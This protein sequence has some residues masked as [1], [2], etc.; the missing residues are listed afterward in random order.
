MIF[1]CP[2]PDGRKIGNPNCPRDKGLEVLM[3]LEEA[4]LC[5]VADDPHRQLYMFN[6]IEYDTNTLGEEYRRD[7]GSR[8]NHEYARQLFSR[9]KHLRHAGKPLAQ[10]CPSAVWQLDQRGLPDHALMCWKIL[11]KHKFFLPFA[12]VSAPPMK[13]PEG[14]EKVKFLDVIDASRIA[15]GGLKD[16]ATGLV[17]PTL[18]LGVTGLSRSGKTVFITALV[19]ALTKG[20]RLP[21]FEAHAQGRITRAYLEPQPDYDLPRFAYEDHLASPH[22]QGSRPGPKAPGASASFV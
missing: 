10:P 22:L 5:F 11:V 15:A 16:F 6:H 17:N 8:K 13:V 12:A 9:R 4:G 7:S 18:R 19:H 14:D 20:R 1:P 21:L 2:F 3:E